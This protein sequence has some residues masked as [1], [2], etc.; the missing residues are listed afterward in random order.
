M[1]LTDHIVEGTTEPRDQ[2]APAVRVEEHEGGARDATVETS[3]GRFLADGLARS[4]SGRSAAGAR[5]AKVGQ[6]AFEHRQF[7]P[8]S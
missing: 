6:H 5:G 4:I 3:L 8:R 2:A 1:F 7:A